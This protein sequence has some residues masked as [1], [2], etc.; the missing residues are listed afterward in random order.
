MC[1]GNCVLLTC[2]EYGMKQIADE[3]IA[4]TVTFVWDIVY[5]ILFSVAKT[6]SLQY[7]KL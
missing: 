3:R 2:C 5:K 1:Y 7:S 4:T 6:N